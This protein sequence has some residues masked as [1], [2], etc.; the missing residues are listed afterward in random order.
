MIRLANI[1]EL[2]EIMEIYQ[3]ARAFM[4]KNNNPTQWGT[5]YPPRELTA[6]DIKE[7]RLYVV[8]CEN[9]LCGVFVFFKGEEPDYNIIEGEEFLSVAPYGVIHRIASRGT[10]KGMFK[11]CL[12]FCLKTADSVRI[13]TH[14]DNTV[15]HHTLEKNGFKKR[16][17][18]YLKNGEERLAYEYL[19]EENSWQ[20]QKQN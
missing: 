6:L 7:R 14:K 19:K 9:T 1:G 10:K 2:D 16:G 8:E 12:E 13:D 4:A 15:M 20:S 18:I 3:V 17:I 5:T 11:Q